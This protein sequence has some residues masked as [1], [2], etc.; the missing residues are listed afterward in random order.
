MEEKL[1]SGGI[2]REK[3][4]VKKVRVARFPLNFIEAYISSYSHLF[5]GQEGFKHA[6]MVLSAKLR[7]CLLFGNFIIKVYGTIN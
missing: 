6:L 7:N 2:V 3:K 4:T 5:T 1:W